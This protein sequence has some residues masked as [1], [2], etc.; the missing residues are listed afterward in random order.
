LPGTFLYVHIGHV[1]GTAIAWD[2]ERSAFE[3]PMLIVG[4]LATV[5]VTVYVTR[6]AK[7]KLNEQVDE[8]A[9]IERDSDTDSRPSPDYFAPPRFAVLTS[10]IDFKMLVRQLPCSLS[11]F[12]RSSV[13][14]ASSY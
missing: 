7:R 5:V 2:R 4:L 3:W 1:T 13:R 9:A 12:A 11:T 6:L 8:D 10:S 14:R